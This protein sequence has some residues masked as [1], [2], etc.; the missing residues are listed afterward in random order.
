MQLGPPI[1]PIT[2]DKERPSWASWARDI[3]WTR[4]IY[5]N[6]M[7]IYGDKPLVFSCVTNSRIASC[8]LKLW[9]QEPTSLYR[10]P[11]RKELRENLCLD[12]PA[13]TKLCRAEGFDW[14]PR[15]AAARS[16][17]NSYGC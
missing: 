15:A 7:V 16:V 5:G 3:F 2:S 12:E 4:D 9:R 17:S 14:L 11:T 13:I 8:A 6:Q 1:V 10:I